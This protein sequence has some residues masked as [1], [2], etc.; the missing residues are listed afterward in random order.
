MKKHLTNFVTHGCRNNLTVLCSYGLTVLLI[1]FSLQVNAQPIYQ[2]PNPGF[3]VWGTDQGG[4]NGTTGPVPEGFNSFHSGYCTSGLLGTCQGV[5][6]RCSQSTDVRQGSS[7]QYSLRLFSNSIIGVRANGNITTGRIYMGSTTANSAN[8]YNYTDYTHNPP[9]HFQEFTGTPDSMKF[10]VKYLPGRSQNPNT[11]DKGRIRTYI[12][13]TGECRDAPQYPSGMTETQL[14]YGRAMSE[15]YKEDGGWHCYQVPFEYTGTN[16]QKNNNGNYYVLI[17]MT[18]NSVP[19]GG[20]NNA[21]EVWFDDIE[22]IYSAWLTDL[23]IN[24]VT[25]DGF[26]KNLLTYGG[27]LLT[28]CP[29]GEC[30]FPYPVSAFSW[31]PQVNDIK[32]VVVTNVPGPLDDADGGYTSILVTAED[33]V[34]TKEYKIFYFTN[35]SDD[36]NLLAASYTLDGSTHIAIP[37]NPAQTIYSIPLTNPEEVQI[38]Q[39]VESSIVLS[40]PVTAEIQ[41]IEQP[42]G[43]N[44]KG[45]VVVRAENLKL[46]SY[47]FMFSKVKSANSKLNWIK[48]SDVVIANF[49]SDTLNY[50]HSI[51]TCVTTLPALTYEKASVYSNVAY[52]PATLTNRTATFT[53]TAENG[54]VSVYKVTF[55]LTNNNA[56]LLG[57]RVNTTNQNNVFSSTVFNHTYAASLT[58]VPTLS[59]STTAG[60]Q[61]CA[62]STVEFPD[63]IV[64]F[65]DTNKINVTAQDMITKQQYGVIIKNTNCY[66]KQT[67]GSNIGLK[68]LYNGVVRNITVP[69]STNNNDVT[70]NVTIPV[71]GPNE[72]CILME[73]DPQAPVVDTIIYTQPTSRAGNSGRVKVIANDGVANK[74]YIINFTATIS[75]DATLKYITYDGLAVPGF[76]PANENYTLIFPSSVTQVPE[77]D[78]APTFQW[79]SQN[80]IIYTP[81]VTLY[82]TAKI[83]VTAENGTTK[84]TYRIIFEVVPQEKDAY[85]IDIRYHNQTIHGFNP[86]IYNYEIEIPY[87]DPIPPQITVTPSSPTALPFFAAQ[88]QTPPY[89]QKVLV[90]SEDMTVSKLYTVSFIRVKNTN[91]TL[92]NIL[93]NGVSMP[94]FNPEE[95]EYQHELSYTELTAPVVT[96]IPAFQYATVETIQIDTVIGNVTIHVTAEDDAFTNVYTIN[97]TRELSPVT[98]INTIMYDYNNQSY[99]VACAGTATTIVLPVETVGEP[100]ITDILLADNRATF[101][102]D[103]QP[104]AT[105]NLTGTVLVTAED[106]T[107]ETYSFIFQKTLSGST[108]ITGIGYTLGTTNYVIDEFDPEITTYYRILSYNN[109]QIPVVSATAEWQGTQVFI[110]QPTNPFGTAN[111]LVISENDLNNKTY[112]IVFQRKGNP[113]LV[114]LYYSLGNDTYQVPNF[115]PTTFTYNVSLPMATTETPIIGYVLEDNTC[116]EEVLQQPDSPNG[117]F[118]LEIST[119]NYD[120]VVTY[121]L[122]FTVLISQEALLSDLRVN[123]ETVPNFDPHTFN[124]TIDMYPYGTEIPFV[125]AELMYPDATEVTTQIEAFP[126]TATVLVTAGNP[127]IKKTYS[128]SFSMNPGNNTYLLDLFIGGVHWWE[129]EKNRYYYEV[130]LDYGTPVEAYPAVEGIADDVTSIVTK[131]TLED[132]KIIHVKVTSLNGDVAIYKVVFTFKGNNNAFAKMIYVDWK[133]LKDFDKYEHEYTYYLPDGYMGVPDLLAEMEDMN[134][135]YKK[136]IDFETTPIHTKIITFAEDKVTSIEYRIYWEFP[137]AVISYDAETFIRVFPNPSSSIIHFDVTGMGQSGYLEIYAMEGKKITHHILQDGVNIVNVKNLQNG[138]YFYKIFTNQT[139]IG[140]GKFVKN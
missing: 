91:A 139:M 94:D 112:T 59:L 19:G 35:R 50:E 81:A 22:F 18:T 99:A 113:L 90:Y 48:V 63:N 21:D 86:T 43:V 82:D 140:A 49:H 69:S 102:I 30:P 133:P 88:M 53:V 95:F 121:T 10:W 6:T 27:P 13:G 7:G 72:P 128:V 56:N 5:A 12:H 125:E 131:D 110:T 79:L 70:I 65:P 137:N 39:I 93:I 104:D 2:L 129:F 105:N 106:E 96:P 54:N 97:F 98:A 44:S 127:S 46:K 64:W 78:F 77:I 41:R 83:E 58:A 15:F 66:L 76:N 126:G 9:R 84:K 92:A 138:I 40:D 100:F 123:G 42:T 23:K 130:E 80:N 87:S 135:S 45:M 122:N 17:S 134:A 57:Y 107:E 120:E 14:Y 71:V 74:T 20:A 73:A 67:S 68:Y 3:E 52:V 32:S 89:T 101:E 33:G 136:I 1:L 124:Y 62:G 4:N 51:S 47:N 31:T 115:S 29:P 60:Q 85:L 117:T 25:I 103:E 61:V 119:W 109:S 11:T 34:T 132:G 16:T 37:V 24:G 118:K 108:M 38:P 28:G 8:N 75:T 36:N 55:K 114:D 26:Q 116:F 111:V